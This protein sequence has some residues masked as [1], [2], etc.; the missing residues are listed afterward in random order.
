MLI[1]VLT[2]RVFTAPL[3]NVELRKSSV[4]GLSVTVRALPATDAVIG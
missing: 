1:A 3:L 2:V 4:V